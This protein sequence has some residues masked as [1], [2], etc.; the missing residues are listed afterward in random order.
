MSGKLRPDLL[1]T[2]TPP[3]L[4]V[5]QLTSEP[6][7]PSSHPYMEAQILTMDSKRFVLHRSATAHGS[8]ANDPEHRY[9]LCDIDDGNNV[10]NLASDSLHLA[11]CG[12]NFFFG[13]TAP[14][15]WPTPR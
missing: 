10:R 13:P 12:I 11:C 2:N 15:N 14:C 1:D 4:E 9:L 8:R 3:G 6:D 5:I 7:V